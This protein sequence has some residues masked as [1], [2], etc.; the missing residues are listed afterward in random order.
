[1]VSALILHR[2]RGTVL[3]LATNGLISS[4]P[5]GGA[6]TKQVRGIGTGEWEWEG[7]EPHLKLA[8]AS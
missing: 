4:K 8:T 1:M 2:V 7:T 3:A 6:S 5:L